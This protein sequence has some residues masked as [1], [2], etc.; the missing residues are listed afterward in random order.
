MEAIH[1][2]TRICSIIGLPQTFVKDVMNIFKTVWEKTR[3]HS[4]QRN[5]LAFV[6]VVIYRSAQLLGYSLPMKQLIPEIQVSPKRFRNV[7]ISTYPIFGRVNHYRNIVQ[8]IKEICTELNVPAQVFMTAVKILSKERR[9]LM[10]SAHTVAASA[11]VGMAIIALKQRDTYPLMLISKKGGASQAAVTSRMFKVAE[12]R[13][14]SIKQF[15]I[16]ELDKQLPRNYKKLIESTE[17][18]ASPVLRDSIRNIHRIANELNMPYKVKKRAVKLLRA[19]RRT[20]LMT[21]REVCASSAVGLA[22][23]TLG[24]RE[25]H[26]LYHIGKVMGCSASSI[27]ARIFKV[28]RSRGIEETYKISRLSSILPSRYKELLE[29]Q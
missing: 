2:T 19:N 15:K 3:K 8:K 26:A 5:I 27:S 29:K 25:K 18:F 22:V 10:L 17:N 16:H 1:E 21:T 4:G 11:S 23:L 6:P 7:L 12:K 24:L 13:K 20:F 28:L 14:L 9:E